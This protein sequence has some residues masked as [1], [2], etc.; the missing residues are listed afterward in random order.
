ML[1]EVGFVRGTL[2][3]VRHVRRVR[4][5]CCRPVVRP[6]RRPL[7]R[8]HRVHHRRHRRVVR[9]SGVGRGR[10]GVGKC[11]CGRR[12]HHGLLRARRPRRRQLPHGH[13][14]CEH[15]LWRRHPHVWRVA[16]VLG[17]CWVSGVTNG[18]ITDGNGTAGRASYAVETIATS[19]VSSS[20]TSMGSG[21]LV[22][23]TRR[24]EHTHIRVGDVDGGEA[25]RDME[26]MR[27]TQATRD[28][29]ED[30]VSTEQTDV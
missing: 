28:T 18:D 20:M 6:R 29:M 19:V 26:Y 21:V 30:G 25:P 5:R 8:H 24:Q 17:R 3:R 7:R 13:P 15:T 4:R 2:R 9:D 16:R 27:I 22:L 1:G 11:G 12:R 10:G 23:L 14:Q